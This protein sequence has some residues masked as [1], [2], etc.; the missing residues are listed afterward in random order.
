MIIKTS[1]KQMISIVA[2]IIVFILSLFLF[3]NAEYVLP[4]AILFVSGILLQ[5]TWTLQTLNKNVYLFSPILLTIYNI[6]FYVVISGL[7]YFSKFNVILFF[8]V[9]TQD[10]E[11]LTNSTL[12]YFIYILCILLPSII[13]CIFNIRLKLK[14]NFLRQNFDLKKMYYYLLFSQFILVL[15]LCLLFIFTGYNIF[16]VL[17]NLLDFRY[18]YTH[19]FPKYIYTLFYSILYLNLIIVL[20]LMLINKIKNFKKLNFL[21]I[22]NILFFLFWAVISGA[23][24]PFLTL[25]LFFLYIYALKP[26]LNFNLAKMFTVVAISIVVVTFMAYYHAYR[27]ITSSTVDT[28]NVLKNTNIIES[29]FERIDG[30]SNS[31]KYLNK[32]ETEKG[33]VWN[34]TEFNFFKQIFYQINTIIPRSVFPDKGDLT[35]TILTKKVYPDIGAE[36]KFQMIFGGFANL[37]Y[38]GGIIFV[39]LDS[40]LF[41][42]LIVLFQSNFSKYSKYDLFSVLYFF[43]F[44]EFII[45]YFSVGHL[46]SHNTPI[47]IFKSILTICILNCLVKKKKKGY[48]VEG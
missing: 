4:S 40:L 34:Y 46:N 11:F 5:F 18:E 21:F 39:I 23:R 14:I 35:H 12:M 13:F 10:I 41:G 36:G 16:N 7:Y 25:F 45:Y 9:P 1:Q 19:G 6:F 42:L 44:I 38:T 28:T 15:L 29:S 30:F 33:S 27:T 26:K 2:Q 48:Y 20:K 3:C 32:V 17:F 31:I 8:R 37:Y 22:T 43:L 47:F 24:A